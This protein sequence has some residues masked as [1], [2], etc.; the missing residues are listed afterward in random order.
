MNKRLIYILL[1]MTSLTSFGQILTRPIPDKLVVLTFDDAPVTHFTFVAP[2]LK[3]YGFNAT[4][5]VCE[6]PPNYA[7]STKYMTWK[8]IEQLSKMGFEIGNHTKNH[9]HVNRLTRPQLIDELSYIENKCDSLK[10]PKP[11]TFAYPGYDTHPTAIEVLKEKGYRF[12]RAGDDRPYNPIADHPYLVPGYTTTAKNKA[13]IMDAFAQAK[14]GKV[15]VL[16]IH[17]VPDYEHDWVTTPPQLLKEYFQFLKDN[18]YKVIS[19]HDLSK[20]ID[21]DKALKEIRPNFQKKTT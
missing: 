6:F 20:Y 1:S 15:V 2:L 16:T 17:G 8:Q 7:D 3:E 19:M 21:V 4:F 13:Q 14:D 11:T 12:A 5:Y 9:K 10:I 18:H